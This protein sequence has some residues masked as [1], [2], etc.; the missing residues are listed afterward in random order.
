MFLSH[1]GGAFTRERRRRG[2]R[3]VAGG[4][5]GAEASRRTGAQKR[6]RQHF[7]TRTLARGADL[8]A[9]PRD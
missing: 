2:T 3:R 4:G 7:L 5:E 9:P 1:R 6:G 8:D